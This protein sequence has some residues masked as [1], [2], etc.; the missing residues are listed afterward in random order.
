MSLTGL[1]FVFFLPAVLVL[2]WAGPRRAAWQNAVLLLASYVFYLS[3]DP[4]VGW[5]ILLSTAVDYAVGLYLAAHPG[6]GRGRRVALGASVAFNVGF[7]GFFKYAGFFAT[8][9]NDLLGAVG[10]PA[11]VE[12]LKVALPIGISY[13]TLQKLSYTIDLYFDRIPAC[14]NALTFATF[15]AFFPQIVCGPITRA[16]DMVPQFS[17]PRALDAET[18][19][20][21]ARAFLLGFF[22]KAYVAD[23]LGSGFADPVFGEPGR[24]GALS[25]WVALLAYAVHIFCDFGGYS[26]MAIGVGRLLGPSCR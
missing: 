19:A 18:V 12:V 26:F 9:L 7:L 11:S 13:Y 4:A 1:E 15:V 2:H 14:R 24:Y 10:L 23:R 22:M 16:R 8:S 20:A 5:A 17:R 25:H 21:G 6:E 3:W